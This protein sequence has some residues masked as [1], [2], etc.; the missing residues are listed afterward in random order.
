VA[1]KGQ[2]A[3]QALEQVTNFVDQQIAQQAQNATINPHVHTNQ[4]QTLRNN[5]MKAVSSDQ[6][7]LLRRTNKTYGFGGQNQTVNAPAGGLNINP[8]QLPPQQVPQGGVNLREG[9]GVKNATPNP[10]GIK[11]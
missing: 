3:R 10:A 4:L 8:S 6:S 9:M 1:T 2:R 11:K 5:L 7:D